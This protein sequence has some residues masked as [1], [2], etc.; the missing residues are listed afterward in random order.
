MSKIKQSKAQHAEALLIRRKKAELTG[1][2]EETDLQETK[3]SYTDFV[4]K[5]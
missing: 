1:I 2:T 5:F 4:G 3:I